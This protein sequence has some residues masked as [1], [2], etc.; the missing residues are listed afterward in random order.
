MGEYA[1]ELSK[2]ITCERKKEGYCLI[3]DN[4]KP[5]TEDHVPPKSAVTITRTE[6]KLITEAFKSAPT[7]LKGVRSRNGNKFKTIC[8]QCNSS[9]AD[10]DTEIGIAYKEL[11]KKINNYFASANRVN[12][13]VSV[14]IN[15]IKYIRAMAGHIL[16]ATSEDEC[17][18]KQSD[19][20]YFTPIKNFVLGKSDSI[21]DSHDIYYWFYPKGRHLSAKILAFHNKGNS[22]A[23]SLLSF[24]PVAFLITE[25]GKG[26]YP[27]QATKLDSKSE[28]LL[29]DLSLRNVNYV[30]FPFTKLEDWQF[31]LMPDYTCTTSYPIK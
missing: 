12:S 18:Q 17:Q 1:K 2:R 8:K 13:F 10:G 30:D 31:Y 6:Q 9:L 28:S 27:V 15:P 24:F 22:S 7:N 20:P 5:L 25:K 3:C 26:I 21:D 19:S 14:K 4:H 16:A 29:L 11:T 23:I